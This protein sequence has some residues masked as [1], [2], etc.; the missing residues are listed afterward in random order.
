MV[1]PV[2]VGSCGGECGGSGN[3]RWSGFRLGRMVRSGIFNITTLLGSG[4]DRFQPTH[5]PIDV[6]AEDHV[7]KKGQNRHNQSQ[8]GG[9]ESLGNAR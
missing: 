9:Q 7:G 3:C 2:C 8:G 1:I 5:R 6:T 4:N